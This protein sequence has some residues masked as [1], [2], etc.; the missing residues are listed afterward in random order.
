MSFLKG[1]CKYREVSSNVLM[2]W[3]TQGVFTNSGD[4]DY[5]VNSRWSLVLRVFNILQTTSAV[6][7]VM[8]P[9]F[10]LNSVRMDQR[11]LQIALLWWLDL[12]V[13]DLNV[14]SLCCGY[15]Q[16][17]TLRKQ[18]LLWTCIWSRDASS[19]SWQQFI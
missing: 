3:Q 2:V 4:R 19:N 13:H 14:S 11:G 15:W 16:C 9:I 17:E 1:I 18:P 8:T 10:F 7:N 12:C 5:H 6:Q